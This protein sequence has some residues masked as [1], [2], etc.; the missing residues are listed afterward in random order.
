MTLEYVSS[1]AVRLGSL[2]LAQPNLNMKMI[3]LF[4][5]EKTAL[6]Q[7]FTVFVLKYNLMN[8]QNL[9]VPMPGADVEEVTAG[10]GN[11]SIAGGS[12]SSEANS[13]TG[14]GAVGNAD[15]AF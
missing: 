8:K 7:R 13:S 4:F 1:T 3:V 5:Q 2:Q 10:E 9:L 15:S 11:T 6:C 12:A 14:A